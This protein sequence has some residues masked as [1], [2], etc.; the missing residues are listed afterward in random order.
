MNTPKTGTFPLRA[1]K[2]FPAEKFVLSDDE[3]ET[4]TASKSLLKK[5]V[6]PRPLAPVK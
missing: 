3:P 6:D 4:F 2:R 5:P 1:F